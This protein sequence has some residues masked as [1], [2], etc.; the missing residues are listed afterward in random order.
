[1]WPE[2]RPL[3]ARASGPHLASV[4]F[5][6]SLYNRS[7]HISE[8]S[9]KVDMSL[10]VAAKERGIA[11]TCDVSVFSLFYTHSDFPSSDLGGKEDLEALW[12]F[13]EHID[14]FS[15]G[16]ISRQI[17]TDGENQ[18]SIGHLELMLPLLLTSVNQ[19]RIKLEEVVRRIH[20]NPCKIFGLNPQEST[21]ITVEMD[22]YLNQSPFQTLFNLGER[23][24]HLQ[25]VVSRVT[26]GNQTLFL[27]GKVLSKP[28]QGKESLA[29]VSLAEPGPKT[30]KRRMSLLGEQ[31]LDSS[32][33]PPH[34]SP[35]PME[36][37]S[38]PQKP[39]K[40]LEIAKELRLPETAPMFAFLSFSLISPKVLSHSQPYTA[41]GS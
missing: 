40:D 37:Q 4:L 38:P 16:D 31:P 22:R 29:E 7:I 27:D 17:K 24:S 8:V 26:V 15:S 3:I 39:A 10:V 12:G 36:I 28:G 32:S 13:M 11:V 19:G 20:E 34:P 41:Q 14:C 35:S 30:K 6:A 25:G 1:M 9:S 21:F 5:F 18:P 2:K 33:H 23:F